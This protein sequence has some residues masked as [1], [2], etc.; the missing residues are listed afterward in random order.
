MLIRIPDI[1]P[2][3]ADAP[4]TSFDVQEADTTRGPWSTIASRPL[5]PLD[6]TPGVP[7]SRSIEATSLRSRAVLRVAWIGPQPTTYSP[8]F[9]VSDANADG[10]VVVVAT[11]PGARPVAGTIAR[12]PSATIRRA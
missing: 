9:A 11:A 3:P 10:G 2:P 5:D 7:V 12:S 8:I 1:S 4:W 6:A